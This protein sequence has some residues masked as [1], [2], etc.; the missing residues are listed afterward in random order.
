[1]LIHQFTPNGDLLTT[2]HFFRWVIKFMSLFYPPEMKSKLQELA[3]LKVGEFIFL[4]H[5]TYLKRIK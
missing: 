4:P 5:G 1:M 2:G 3:K